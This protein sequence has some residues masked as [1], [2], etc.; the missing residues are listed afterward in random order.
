MAGPSNVMYRLTP[1]ESS[2]IDA[3]PNVGDL[4]TASYMVTG[5]LAGS[6]SNAALTTTGQEM[7]DGTINPYSVAEFTWA[8]AT[9][10]LAGA[11]GAIAMAILY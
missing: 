11:S 5:G 6:T 9:S 3:R 4:A 7:M 1:D 2:S 8:G 10:C